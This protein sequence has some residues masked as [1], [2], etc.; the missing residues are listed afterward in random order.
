MFNNRYFY[1][2]HVRKA[3]ISFGTLFNNI[4]IRRTNSEGEA[5]Q[6]LVV[7]LSYAPK[8]KFIGRIREVPDLEEGRATFAITLP[9]MGFEITNFNYDPSRK[10]AITQNVRAVDT[11]G[12]TN[13]GVRYSFIS[14][15]YN[16]GIGMSVFAKNQDDGLQ[17]IEQI[18][19]Y[20]NP[21]FN[22]TINE[23][24]ELGVKRDLQIVLDNISYQDEWEGDFDKRLSVIWDLNFTIKMNFFGYVQDANLIKKTIQSIY[25]DYGLFEGGPPTNNQVGKRITTYVNPEDAT[26]LDNYEFIQEFD[27]IF[28][29]ES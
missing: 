2:Q 26:P 5:A 21:D 24:P 4:R 28:A 17:I 20:F 15:P 18:L 19:P 6:S 12:T 29:S 13:T 9:R 1:H 27:D 14:T 23:I 10:L 22:V 3:I 11:S 8:Q 7:P 16:M 25:T